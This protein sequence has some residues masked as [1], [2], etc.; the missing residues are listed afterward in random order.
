MVIVED[1]FKCLPKQKV[2]KEKTD[3]DQCYTSLNLKVWTR[4]YL[5][6][7]SRKLNKLKI[8]H[9]RREQI[10]LQSYSS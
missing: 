5:F 9:N 4:S 7:E 10:P 6:N 3:S 8:I 2:M 1:V